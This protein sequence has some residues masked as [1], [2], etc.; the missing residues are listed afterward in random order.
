M[1]IITTLG[2]IF[3]ALGWLWLAIR[4]F[5]KGDTIGGIIFL[6]TAILSAI[7]FLRQLTDKKKVQ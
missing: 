1:K 2:F 3:A 4:Y 5:G 7:L 6:V